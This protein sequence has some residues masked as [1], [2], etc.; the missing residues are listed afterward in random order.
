MGN[1]EATFRRIVQYYVN[2]WSFDPEV[3]VRFFFLPFI[4]KKSRVCDGGECESNLSSFYFVTWLDLL[5]FFFQK[6]RAWQQAVQV[7]R[8]T[9]TFYHVSSA[10]DE[11]VIAI[12][13]A[14]KRLSF[15]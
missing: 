6:A 5:A 11:C 9:M 7:H 12:I 13:Y 15:R 3:I 8:M 10:G 4:S 1:V 14:K 2:Y